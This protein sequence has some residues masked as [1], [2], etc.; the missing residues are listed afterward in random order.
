M[1]KRIVIFTLIAVLTAP[2]LFAGGQEEAAPEAAPGAVSELPR[3]EAQLAHSS[4]PGGIAGAE[5]FRDYLREATDG[6][7]VINTIDYQALGSVREVADQIRLGEMEMT[8][9]GTVGLAHIW[10]D[11][12]MV[13]LPFLFPNRD[14]FWQLMKDPEYVGYI[15]DNIT[16]ASRQTIRYLGAAENSVRHLYVDE[17]IRVPDDLQRYNI[18]IRVQ[19]SPIMQ[20]VWTGLGAGEVVAMSGS[21]RN[22]AIQAGT[23]D[24]IEGSFGGAWRGGNLAVLGNATLTGHVYDYMHYFINA[25]FYNSLPAEYQQ[26]I[27]E[28]TIVAIDAHN[29]AAF[30]S[31]QESIV[32]A[33]DAGV[34][35][36]EPT[37]EETRQWQ[38]RAIPAGERFI[39]GQVSETFIELTYETIERISQ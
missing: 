24:A 13:N 23:L 36:H 38:A 21:E 33:R 5:A 39:Q 6:R 37:A 19:E 20:A 1:N 11:L 10:P 30:Q 4:N 31:E 34:W 17:Q 3:I 18:K 25:E 27:D 15:R 35:I 2:V 9:V 26:V 28:A 22:A 14:V 12:Q 8:A 32:A 7:F 16:A 29:N